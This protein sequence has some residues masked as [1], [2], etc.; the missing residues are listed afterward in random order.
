MKLGNMA[1]RIMQADSDESFD[2]HDFFT[3]E[4]ARENHT[5][6]SPE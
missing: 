1:F 5:A 6:I 3:G 2:G 4:S